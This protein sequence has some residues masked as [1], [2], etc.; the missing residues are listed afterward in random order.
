M[1]PVEVSIQLS[2]GAARPTS[3]TVV[4]P[5][6][7]NFAKDC[8]VVGGSAVTSCMP[9]PLFSG[10]P[11]ARLACNLGPSVTSINGLKLRVNTPA[12][13][14]S[15]RAWLVEGLVENAGAVGWGE[16]SIGFDLQQMRDVSIT[17]PGVP[18]VETQLAVGFRTSEKLDRGSQIEILKPEAFQ[19]RCNVATVSTISLP[20]VLDCDVYKA[21]IVL[22][23]SETLQGGE[24]AFAL[25]IRTPST[26]PAFNEWSLLLK[27]QKG[28]VQDA[29]MNIAGKTIQPDF[30][31]VSTPLRWTSSDAGQASTITIGFIVAETIPPNQLGDL[32]IT[33]PENFAHAIEQECS[34]ESSNGALPLLA[35][36]QGTCKWVDIQLADRV[37]IHLD[38]NKEVPP[39]TYELSFPVTVPEQMPAYNV[40]LLTFCQ[41]ASGSGT[42][43]QAHSSNA[44][45][46]FPW[47]GFSHGSMPAVAAGDLPA[48]AMRSRVSASFWASFAFAVF[49]QY[50]CRW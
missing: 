50:S 4:A 39:G 9:G 24:Y 3:L 44:L 47:A 26:T 36:V 32:L 49:L 14:P 7:I 38:R 15:A 48:A 6:G 37:V 12:Q 28:F 21:S 40:W 17:Y 45:V 18:G 19:S 41:P 2:L 43:L 23:L 35:S 33:L 20:P 16:D 11:T 22:T 5:A 31:M 10:Q 46:T 13:T 1:A 27:S 29:A 42:C 34:V 25:L 8:L 30:K